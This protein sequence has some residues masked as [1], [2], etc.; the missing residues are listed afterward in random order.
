MVTTTTIHTAQVIAHPSAAAEPVVN[1]RHRGRYP[2]GVIGLARARHMRA[3]KQARAVPSAVRPGLDADP[4]RDALARVK[5]CERL[6]AAVPEY[7][8]NLREKM[9]LAR[10]E[11]ELVFDGLGL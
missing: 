10:L 8:A 9:A 7:E 5:A 1:P 11:V 3:W 2:V 6:L 4:R